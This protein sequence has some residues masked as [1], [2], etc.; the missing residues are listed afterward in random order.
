LTHTEL[1]EV[2]QRALQTE[3]PALLAISAGYSKSV[4]GNP[5]TAIGERRIDWFR[6]AA[7]GWFVGGVVGHAS[8]ATLSAESTFLGTSQSYKD[9]YAGINFGSRKNQWMLMADFLRLDNV[10][11]TTLALSYSIHR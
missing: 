9:G 3:F 10:N 4:S 6:P 11:R 7:A 2:L 1:L 8:P 5:D